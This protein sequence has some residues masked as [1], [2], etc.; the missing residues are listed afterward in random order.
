VGSVEDEIVWSPDSKA[1][2][3]NGN[4]NGY[5]DNHLAVHRLDDPHLAPGYITREV[6]QDMVRSFPP[7]QAKDHM[8]IC[9]ELA[10]NPN[11]YIG[12]VGLDWIGSSSKIVVMAEVPCSSSMGGIMCQVLGYQLEVPSGKILRRMEPG[13]FTKRWQHRM[14]WKFRDPGPA[15]L[16]DK[17]GRYWDSVEAGSKRSRFG[18]RGKIWAQTFPT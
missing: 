17:Q 4:D 8:D 3:I 10:A 9:S 18:C 11:S 1:F 14:A 2:F 5:G 7:C 15:E 16:E 6:E 13:E 12:V